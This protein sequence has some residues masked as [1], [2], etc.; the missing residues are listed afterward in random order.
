MKKIQTYLILILLTFIAFSM[1]LNAQI[2]AFPTAEGY[3]KYA[4]GGRGGKVVFVDN[5]KDYISYNSLET[6]IPGSF[7]W[8]LTQYPGDS[9]TVIFR[10]SG[11]IQLKPYLILSGTTVKNQNDI[12]C[13]RAN[14]TIAGQTAPGEGIQIRN[15]KVNLGSSVNLVVRNLRFRIGELAEPAPIYGY[16]VGGVAKDTLAPVGSFLPGGSVGCENAVNVIFDHCDFGWS[17]EENLTMYDNRYTTLQWSILHDALYN[18]G[19]GKGDRSYGSQTG[20]ICAT[21]HHNLWTNNK[22]RSPRLNGA[23]T[24]NEMNVFIEFI[25]NLVYN[26]GSANAAYGGDILATGTR[27]HTCNFVNNYY[28]PGPATP[29]GTYYFFTNYINT[30]ASSIPKWYLSGN[31][32]EGSS[33]LNTN[34]WAGL[35]WK[36]S[37]AGTT[38]PTKATSGSDTLLLPPAS[39]V[40]NSAWV[41]YVPYKLSAIQSAADAYNDILT[42]VGTVNRDSVER[43]IIRE[44]KNKTATFKASLGSWGIIDKSYDAE[45]YLTYAS[46]VAP[47]DTDN[48]GMPDAWEAANG[49]NSNN[50][51]D[52]NMRTSEGYTALEVY[53]A[54][55]MGENIVHDFISAVKEVKSFNV[56]I[57]PTVVK[58][59]FQVIS[60]TPLQSVKIVDLRGKQ[61][62]ISSISGST[63]VDVSNLAKGCYLVQIISRSGITEQF[64]IL[65]E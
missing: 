26:W 24:D 32:M 41:K 13:S 11:I 21:Y 49:L 65:K 36:W 53:L 1:T 19:H 27:S 29:T 17:G 6:P 58:K 7:R 50:P 42:K 34:N 48:D 51:D 46:A 3:G 52:R 44:V 61:I 40:Y 64:K 60:D 59:K 43:R 45:G 15:G 47:T 63:F 16:K 62:M 39:V 31:I 18:D 55:L 37:T 35:T 30:G 56:S 2:Q 38:L 12:R 54:S 4:K 8:A 28:K 57:V 9:L 33:A 5:L 22:T 23:R 25:N 14:L 10:V 20:G